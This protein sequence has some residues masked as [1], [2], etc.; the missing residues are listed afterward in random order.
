M[1][2]LFMPRR[3]GRRRPDGDAAGRPL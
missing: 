2:P 3:S 1:R